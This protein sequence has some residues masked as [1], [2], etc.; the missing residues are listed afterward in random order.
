MPPPLALLLCTAFVLFLLWLERRASRGVSAALWIPTLWMLMTGSRSLDSWFSLGV[1]GGNDSGGV[2]DRWVLTGLTVAAVAVLAHRRF[3]WSG[4]LRRHKWLL[5]L[6][7]Y[8]FASTLWSDIP[9]I[10]LRRWAREAIVVPM[11]LFIMS[12]ANPRQ[13]LASLLRRSAYVLIPFSVVV[14]KYYAALGRDYGRWF[15]EVSWIGVTTQKNQL[16]RL[17][18]ISIFFLLWTLY[19][20]RRERPPAGGRYQGWAADVFVIVIALYLLEGADSSTSLATLFVGTATFLG[21]HLFRKLKV[22]VPQTGLLALLTILAVFGAAAPFLGGS[23]VAIFSASLNRDSTLTGRTEIW[24][25]VLPAI[26]QR[27]LLGYG[28]GSFWTDA[29]RELYYHMPSAHNGYL[30]ILLELGEVGLAFYAI[31]LLSCARQLHRALA[32]DYEWASLAICFLVMTLIYNT[33]ESALNSLVENIS[34]VLVFASLV[35]SCEPATAKLYKD[36]GVIAA[37]TVT[38]PIVL[39]VRT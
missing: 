27:A 15:G 21:L 38:T 24:A 10:T 19:R 11:A 30:D 6:L 33:T 4:T 35:A 34:A 25:A 26:K 12:E 32:R 23:N 20:R 3:D 17:C 39:E 31:W 37:T 1:I 28:F 29:R 18:T 16:G 8:M 2:L 7:L 22:M 9:L 5:V 13:A 14:I 36:I